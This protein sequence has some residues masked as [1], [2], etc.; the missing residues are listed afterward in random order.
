MNAYNASLRSY[1]V[2]NKAMETLAFHT[3]YGGDLIRKFGYREC[4][5]K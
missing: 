1:L 4:P 3:V 2:A 5:K